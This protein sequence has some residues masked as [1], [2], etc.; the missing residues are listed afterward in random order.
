MRG[1]CLKSDVLE[2]HICGAPELDQLAVDH[3]AKHHP[4]AEVDSIRNTPEQQRRGE[5]RW[6]RT[7]DRGYSAHRSRRREQQALAARP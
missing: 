7:W 1:T 3:F 5:T 6:T 2:L 4:E